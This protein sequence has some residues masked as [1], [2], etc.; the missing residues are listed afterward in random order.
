MVGTDVGTMYRGEE[1]KGYA[2]KFDMRQLL[3][4]QMAKKTAGDQERKD[5]LGEMAKNMPKDVWHYYSANIQQEYSDWMKKGA[6]IMTRKGI[7]DPWK[8]AD[9]DAVQWQIDGA[10]LKAK[11]ENIKQAKDLYEKGMQN[12]ASNGEKYDPEYKKEIEEFGIRHSYEE[13]ASGGYKFPKAV[14]SDPGN[15]YERFFVKDVQELKSLTKDGAV[16]TDAAIKNRLD[17]FF[18]APENEQEKNAAQQMFS[19]LDEQAKQKY[20]AMSEMMGYDESP[21]MA[22]AFDNYKK[23]FTATPRNLADDVIE[24]A[25]KAPKNTKEYSTEDASGVTVG[26]S[27]E[28]LSNEKYPS[29]AAKSYFIE[30][31]YLLDDPDFMAQLGIKMDVPRGERKQNAVNRLTEIIRQNIT[32]KTQSFTSRQGSASGFKDEEIK[33]NYDKWRADIGSA[34]PAVASQAAKYLYGLQSSDGSGKVVDAGVE[35]NSRVTAP[36]KTNRYLV[37]RYQDAKEA[38]KFKDKFLQ[39]A[40]KGADGLNEDQLRALREAMSFY[41][42]KSGPSQVAIPVQPEYEQILKRMHDQTARTNKALYEY[43]GDKGAEFNNI[44][45]SGS[46]KPGTGKTKGAFDDL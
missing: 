24:I 5:A 42:Q 18:G 1:G 17:V 41:E 37:I 9:Q 30:N 10:N 38:A 43:Q 29:L 28:K 3:A 2:E 21:W 14:F 19:D 34:D 35:I 45:G 8:S 6:D 31:S 33:T 23:R 25:E 46:S 36:F 4:N 32:Q 11:V 12:I 26:G 13:I 40:I 44:G 27:S 16:P 15:L 20:S 22:L 7:N 39:E